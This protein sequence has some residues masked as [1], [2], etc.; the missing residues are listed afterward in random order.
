MP[1]LV[2]LQT[3]GALQ[4]SAVGAMGGLRGC[5]EERYSSRWD[6][7]LIRR[8]SMEYSWMCCCAYVCREL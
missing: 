1:P 8:P 3:L 7:A 6:N 2:G 5:F 4:M